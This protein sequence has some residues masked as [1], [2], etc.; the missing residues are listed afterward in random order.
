MTRHPDEIIR[1]LRQRYQ[2][3]YTAYQSCVDA[4]TASMKHG[5]PT[6][7]LLEKEAAALR[8]LNEARG[9]FRDALLDLTP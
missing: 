4:L 8:E 9:A 3:A 7:E 5:G 2:A 6:D 1:E